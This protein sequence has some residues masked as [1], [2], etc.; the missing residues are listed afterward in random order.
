M[1]QL[2]QVIDNQFKQPSK[3]YIYSDWSE[4]KNIKEKT[5]LDNKIP[6][7]N[8]LAKNINEMRNKFLLIHSA[9]ELEI[10]YMSI[11]EKKYNPFYKGAHNAAR[12]IIGI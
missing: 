4:I 1:I 3:V 8:T 9:M 2:G 12:E 10:F 11:E 7:I 5:I 6:A